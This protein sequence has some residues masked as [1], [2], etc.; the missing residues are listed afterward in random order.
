MECSKLTDSVGWEGD[1]LGRR[2]VANFLDGVIS[3]KV[4]AQQVNGQE[5]ALCIAI[6][7]DWGVG[8]TFFVDRWTKELSGKQF[9]VVRFDA[10]KNDLADD[11]LIGFISELKHTLEPWIA[12]LPVS[13]KIRSG[14][15]KRT[16]TVIKQAARA[17]LPLAASAGTAFAARHFGDQGIAALKDA[18]GDGGDPDA[19]VVKP[20]A[21]FKISDKALQA[22]FESALKQ[23]QGKQTAISNLVEQLELLVEFMKGE[24]IIQLPLFIF[25]D[26]LDR[27]RP[28]Y[29]IRLLEGMKHLFNAKGVCFVVTTNLLQ[30]SEAI[31]AVYGNNFDG[32]GYLKRFFDFEYQLPDPEGMA[33]ARYLIKTST[34]TNRKLQTGIRV[35]AGRWDSQAV[36]LDVC[37]YRVAQLFSLTLRSQRQ[38]LLQTEAAA[39]ALPNT[40]TIHIFY[41]FCLAATA[42]KRPDVIA[43]LNNNRPPNIGPFLDTLPNLTI[44]YSGRR[45][46]GD[47]HEGD[48]E[49]KSLFNM[50]QGWSIKTRTELAQSSARDDDYPSGLLFDLAR[51]SEDARGLTPLSAYSRC[52]RLAGQMFKPLMD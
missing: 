37:F 28:D 9:P 17:T 30:L 11:P 50:Y 10:W 51:E 44:S 15:A 2:D 12:R 47:Y 26:E 20:A 45:G 1:V 13:A 33:Y 52:V 31:K 43:V 42:H 19:D 35:K 23:H 25:I 48:I 24:P 14:L 4:A 49:L 5:G 3:A 36:A 38:V 8:K 18:F 40:H 21:Q 7:G 32:Y 16:K 22:F 46:N 39:T 6:D 34:L 27:C 41:L 29:A